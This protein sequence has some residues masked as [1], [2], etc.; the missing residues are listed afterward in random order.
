MAKWR[1]C[2][3]AS[4]LAVLALLLAGSGQAA[5]EIVYRPVPL[6]PV[7]GGLVVGEVVVTLKG[8]STMEV[9]QA[10]ATAGQLAASLGVTVGRHVVG[11]GSD[12]FLLQVAVGQEQ[13]SA[14][15]L[16]ADNRVQAAD[17]NFLAYAF[18]IP[19]DTL[20]SRFQW[21][22]PRINAPTAWDL[23][24]GSSVKVAVIDTGIDLG[25]PDLSSSVVGGVDFSG[26][27]SA[28]GQDNA[29]H[30]T[31]VAGIIGA[32]TNN[33]A[34]VAGVG[35]NVPLLAAKV[36]NHT[37]VGSYA[38]IIQAIDWARSQGAYVINL[39]L[40]GSDY[41]Q[42]MQEA[43][44][45]AY[46]AGVVVV[47]A[48][49]NNGQ[50]GSYSSYPCAMQHVL[51]VGAIGYNDAVASY[52][53]HNSYVGVVAPGGDPQRNGSNE[54]SYI[55]STWWRADPTA[56]DYLGL[57]GTSMAAPHVAGLAALLIAHYPGASADWIV[58]RIEHSALDYGQPGR[59]DYYGWGRVDAACALQMS[60]NDVGCNHW[61]FSFVGWLA[62]QGISSGDAAG[63][64]NPNAPT[65]RDEFAKFIVKAAGWPL[66]RPLTATFSDVL[67]S[68]PLYSYIETAAAHGAVSGSGG[69]FNPAA[70]VRRDEMAKIIVRAQ[71][72]L[73]LNP[74]SPT[75]SDVPPDQPLYRYVETA[76]AH[77]IVDGNG[78]R[79]NPAAGSTRAQI[80]KVLY[81]GYRLLPSSCGRLALCVIILPA[82]HTNG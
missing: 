35:W 15:R 28:G 46:E 1:G 30:G 22:L 51:C 76:Y 38:A 47:A 44:N 4:K 50:Y 52:S 8:S 41:S 2:L 70:A 65:R 67:P 74:A 68:Q 53:N 19:N 11:S 63:N 42:A 81:R 29:G 13:A 69:N 58:Q 48:A 75:F 36:L 49:G 37:G 14:V 16:R 17:P 23:Q 31:H 40:G 72:W 78:D 43:I 64:F 18:S 55:M 80:S 26:D 79:Y 66:T 25:H 20:Y 6:A 9:S 34:G 61:A 33:G 24:G 12:F 59:D 32:I 5:E 60:F 71:G 45:R 77:N 82:H 7:Q 3:V 39:S 73:L 27:G 57:A 54:T 56:G 62:A 10:E 21:N